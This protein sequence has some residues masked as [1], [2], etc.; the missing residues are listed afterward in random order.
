[1]AAKHRMRTLLVANP[2]GGSGKTTLATNLAGY[3]AASGH[4]VGILDLDRQR[5]ATQWLA[6]RD[7]ALP[8]IEASHVGG[9]DWLV[10]DSPAGLHGKNL[11]RALK[12]AEKVLVPIAPSMFDMAASNDFLDLLK[13]ER[14]VRRGKTFVGLVG[15]RIDPRTRAG[16]TVQEYLE[17]LGLPVLA[18]LRYAQSYVAAA[19]EGKSLFDLPPYLAERELEQWTYLI[20]WL[21]HEDAV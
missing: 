6:M 1:M 21:N 19:F 17:G 18:Y 2:K 10:I 12:L 16:L 7:P 15:M 13:T 11:E 20:D 3:L 8:V 9:H 14:E 4:R 5:S